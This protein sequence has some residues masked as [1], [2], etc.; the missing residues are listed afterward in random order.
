V[1]VVS[2]DTGRSPVWIAALN[3][4]SA[5]RQVTVNDGRKAYFVAGGWVVFEGEENGTNLIFRVKEDGTELQEIMRI[6]G[7]SALF[8][9]S[10]DGRWVV[11]PRSSDEM[12]WPAMLYPVSGG[13]PRP[14]CLTCAGGNNV[15]RVGPPGVSWSL[16]GKFLYLNF[17][18]SIYA[19]PLPLG[20]MLP[21]IPASGFKSKEDVA[22]LPGAR[23]IPEQGAFPGPNP[24]IYAFTKVSTHRNIYRVSV[25]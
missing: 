18:E 20:Q 7:P 25:P 6:D 22:A 19:I 9:A 12:A 13:S 5:P 24:S 10:P 3:G 23:L 16:D 4:R 14:L 21:P 11:V 15:E 2:D 1:F 8:S 17:R